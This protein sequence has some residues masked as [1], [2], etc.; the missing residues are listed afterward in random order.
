MLEKAAGNFLH[1]H[2][3]ETT[4]YSDQAYSL[5]VVDLEGLATYT[6]H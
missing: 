2:I 3:K 4:K 1:T 5:R 6:T